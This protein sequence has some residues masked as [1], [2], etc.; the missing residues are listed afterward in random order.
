MP[1]KTTED[2]IKELEAKIV[3]LKDR[4][5]RKKAR[6]NPAVKF[7]KAAHK[8]VAQAMAATEDAVLR[9]SLEEVQLSLGANLSL[10]GVTT[11]GPKTLTPRPGRRG[12]AKASSNGHT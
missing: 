9:K 6:A 2:R 5:E 7:M 11:R 3:S 1:R 4:A 10:L 12:R 8:N